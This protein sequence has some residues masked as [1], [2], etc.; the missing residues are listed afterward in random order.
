MGDKLGEKKGGTVGR[1]SGREIGR[2][3]WRGDRRESGREFG[4]DSQTKPLPSALVLGPASEKDKKKAYSWFHRKL[5]FF[6]KSNF[7]PLLWHLS[8]Y[9][10]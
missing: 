3:S 5:I 7:Y 6:E 9:E 1:E 2:E 4:R 8:I 10:N